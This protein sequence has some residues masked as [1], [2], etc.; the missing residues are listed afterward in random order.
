MPAW[1]T[2]AF[3]LQM[4]HALR[5]VGR[6]VAL[7]GDAAHAVHPLAGQGLNLGL[8]DCALLAD[9]VENAVL[10]G[11]D[12]GGAAVLRQYEGPAQASNG[13]MMAGLHGACP[14]T[15]AL[16]NRSHLRFARELGTS[17]FN[18]EFDRGGLLNADGKPPGGLACDSFGLSRG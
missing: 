1:T 7:V 16:W 12:V 17:L 5:Y 6:R 18:R 4:S 10:T 15:V 8:A 3:P 13:V 14:L 2:G 11:G 9:A